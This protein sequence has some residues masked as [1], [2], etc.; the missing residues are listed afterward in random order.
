MPPC[1]LH[2][3]AQHPPAPP[4]ITEHSH[5]RTPSSTALL[6]YS[7][8]LALIFN[9]SLHLF[10]TPALPF[11]FNPSFALV[12]APFGG[13]AMTGSRGLIQGALL[14]GSQGEVV[15]DNAPFQLADGPVAQ[16]IL[17]PIPV[18][19][20]LKMQRAWL[21]GGANREPEDTG[22]QRLLTIDTMQDLHEGHFAIFLCQK[23][24]TGR[25]FHRGYQAVARQF[26]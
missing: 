24:S 21:P 22:T 10:S 15:V 11:F 6:L 4:L 25:A 20:H 13:T 8:L 16:L 3:R 7:P 19:H 1:I 12:F 23:K 14:R 9:P 2:I 17:E 18:S 26:L 5:N